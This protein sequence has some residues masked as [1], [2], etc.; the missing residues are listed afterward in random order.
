MQRAI[1]AMNPLIRRR[2]PSRAGPRTGKFAPDLGQ[3][4]QKVEANALTTGKFTSLSLMDDSPSAPRLEAKMRHLIA[5]IVCLAV[6]YAVD[7]FFFNG[8]Y[9][10]VA[11][12]VV[13]KAS[14][15]T[16]W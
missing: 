1:S 12:Q 16:W 6:L 3:S 2:R 14:T 13:E 11:A 15:V 8:W 4:R 10:G 7:S 9:F 5:A